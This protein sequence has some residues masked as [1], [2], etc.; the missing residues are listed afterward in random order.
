LQPIRKNYRVL[1]GLDGYDELSLTGDTRIFSAMNDELFSPRKLGLKQLLPQDLMGG[2]TPK[3]SARI[4]EHILK[5]EGTEAQSNVVA[6]ST[7]QALRVFDPHLDEKEAFTEAL[8]VIRKGY[9]F[10]V[11][12]KQR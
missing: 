3:D 11:L 10:A 9:P 4:L 7:A 8:S 12:T 2:S 6:A 5:G 1:Y